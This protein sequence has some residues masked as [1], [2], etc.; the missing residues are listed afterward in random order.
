MH[1][2]RRSS[3]LQPYWRIAYKHQGY[4]AKHAYVLTAAHCHA[5]IETCTHSHHHVCAVVAMHLYWYSVAIAPV[6]KLTQQVAC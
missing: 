3:C 5:A 2:L 4:H 1:H 6:S